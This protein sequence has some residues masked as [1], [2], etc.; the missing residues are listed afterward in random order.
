MAESLEFYRSFLKT[1]PAGA[2]RERVYLCAFG[3]HPGWNDHIEDLGLDTDTLAAARSLL[4]I[5][6]I[7]GLVDAAAWD[8][9]GPDRLLPELRHF[10]L[11]HRKGEFLLG[12]LWP[13]KD[14]KG[15]DRYP[16]GVCFHVIGIA[17]EAAL[18]RLLPRLDELENACRH[19]ADA[20]AVVRALDAAREAAR[21]DLT[22]DALPPAPPEHYRLDSFLKQ[23]EFGADRVGLWRAW[24]QMGNQLERFRSGRFSAKAEGGNGRG[25]H[26]RLPL[27]GLSLEEGLLGWIRFLRTRVD[28]EVPCLLLVASG[29]TWID[30]VVGP[31]HRDSLFCL[32]ALPEGLPLVSDIPFT[33]APEFIATAKADLD[34]LAQGNGAPARARSAQA[35]P[36]PPAPPPPRRPAG[37]LGLANAP[38]V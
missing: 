14:G 30:I 29:R 36:P 8:Q 1:P 25:E 9:L 12:K 18:G 33:L 4:Y 13:S 10:F 3:K 32:K 38:G 37:V 6:G 7:G 11:W 17:P 31:P 5:Q 20:P 16:M 28:P 2:G 23:P 27:P 26:I 15:R 21:R 19:A 22:P 24:Y 34:A 35:A